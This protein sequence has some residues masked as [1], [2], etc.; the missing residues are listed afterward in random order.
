MS[1]NRLAPLFLLLLVLPACKVDDALYKN[2]FYACNSASTDPTQCGAG[3]VCYPAHQLGG[4]DFCVPSCSVPDGGA[5][6][7]SDSWCVD[8]EYELKTCDP[9]HPCTAGLNCVRDGLLTPSGSGL[10][11]PVQTC[12]TNADCLDPARGT[13]LSIMTP[14]Q[15]PLSYSMADPPP[16]NQ[17][18]GACGVNLSCL[19]DRTVCVTQ[20]CDQGIVSCAPGELCLPAL[21]R[22]LQQ[23]ATG[24]TPS[25]QAQGAPDLCVPRC[26]GPEHSCP[27]NFVCS[28]KAGLPT[29]GDLF[30]L[31]GFLGLGCSSDTQCFVQNAE[32]C[33]WITP[34]KE[35]CASECSTEAD[36][37]RFDGPGI[38]FGTKHFACVDGKACFSPNSFFDQLCKADKDCGAGYVCSL[39][40]PINGSPG[41]CMPSC[42]ASQFGQLCATD[43]P[44]ACMPAKADN[45]A[46]SPLTQFICAPAD[47]G[48]P[49]PMGTNF[50]VGGMQCLNDVKGTPRCVV[51]CTDTATCQSS[52]WLTDPVS[53]ANPTVCSGTAAGS[54]CALPTGAGCLANFEC[55]SGTCN[56]GTCL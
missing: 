36:C 2:G 54:Y 40:L 50:C 21:L 19:P 3:Y 22:K 52:H 20:G 43:Y 18:G 6:I 34:Q 4:T 13:C 55:V 39:L 51:A 29:E 11:L 24:T 47:V 41:F 9:N 44:T 33:Q 32:S 48:T 12:Q 35:V 49:C 30:C 27:P 15:Y 10:C 53:K 25:M 46:G 31:P 14:A 28:D 1:R 23:D 26:A 37:A 7:S 38:G 17:D 16:G 8:N 42:K 5:P 56:V 45:F